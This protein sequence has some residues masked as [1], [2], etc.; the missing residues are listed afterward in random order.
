ML[1]ARNSTAQGVSPGKTNNN[2]IEP[3]KGG[4]IQFKQYGLLNNI[5]IPAVLW[6]SMKSR[7]RCLVL[8]FLVIALL[9]AANGWSQAKPVAV[10]QVPNAPDAKG[11]IASFDFSRVDDLLKLKDLKVRI[12]M[13]QSASEADISSAHLEMFKRWVSEGGISCFFSNGLT[14]SLFNKLDLVSINANS[15]V[16]KENGTKFSFE[17]G[18]GELFVKGL[19]PNIV[20][21][22]HGIT[23]GVN[24]IYVG[25]M[26]DDQLGRGT[27]RIFEPKAG[28]TFTPILRLGYAYFLNETGAGSIWINNQAQYKERTKN[29]KKSNLSSELATIFG[30][31]E[32][33]SGLI[34]IDGT[35]LMLGKNGLNGNTY[36]WPKM[37]QNIL[38][39]AKK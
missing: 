31:V 5:D 33:G 30:V 24:S 12:V 7:L 9:F 3:C 16:I 27:V 26:T 20:I 23:Q 11:V 35:G 22:E 28:R 10:S 8:P 1:K 39:Y 15:E 29:W 19:L 14:S 37:Y 4:T 32:L 2:G 34:V 36:D 18:I 6:S 21:E 13:F 25:P 38:G 17:K